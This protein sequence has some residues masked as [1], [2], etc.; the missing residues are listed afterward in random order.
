MSPANVSLAGLACVG[1]TEP[2]CRLRVGG[3]W[4]PDRELRLNSSTVERCACG[5]EK[6]SNSGMLQGITLGTG[7][8]NPLKDSK[9][10]VRENRLR[11]MAHRQGLSLWLSRRRDENA[12]DYGL[13]ALTGARGP[14]HAQGPIS[15]YALD[16]DEVEEYLTRVP[17]P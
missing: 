12:V 5:G 13:Y 15:F 7:G 16:L 2:G 17:P 8:G 6:G 14:V 3:H 9:L 10:K 11:R 1:S 4:T